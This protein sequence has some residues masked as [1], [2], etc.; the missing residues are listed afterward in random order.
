MERCF[1]C[2]H[3]QVHAAN[4]TLDLPSFEKGLQSQLDAGVDG[5]VL[6]GS[7]GEASTL[8]T[9][10]KETLVKLANDDSRTGAGGIEHCRRSH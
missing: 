8:T 5:I 9:E 4:D 1:S 6:G 3:Y 7:L 10:E 2:L